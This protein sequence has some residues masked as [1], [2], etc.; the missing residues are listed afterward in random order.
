MS[1]AL[2]VIKSIVASHSCA[3]NQQAAYNTTANSRAKL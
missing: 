3:A 2:V 1:L